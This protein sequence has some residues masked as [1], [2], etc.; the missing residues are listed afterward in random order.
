V[1]LEQF[2]WSTNQ[3]ISVVMTLGDTETGIATAAATVAAIY[4]VLAYHRPKG[5]PVA[6]AATR[7]VRGQVAPEP[8]RPRSAIP[9]IAALV[10]W[11]AVA[12]NFV[13]TNWF[14][15]EL[16]GAETALSEDNASIS[17]RFWQRVMPSSDAHQYFVNVYTLNRGKST[18]IGM[19]HTGFAAVGAALDRSIADAFYLSLRAQLK[20]ATA[21]ASANEIRPGQD[22]V[23]F[24]LVGPPETETMTKQIND[25]SSVIYAFV[26]MRY[27]DNATPKGKYIYTEGCAYF[28]KETTHLCEIGHNRTY[29]SD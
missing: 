7:G 18:A 12:C 4:A 8:V 22:D 13:Y 24:T 19:M 11:A 20:I 9:I 26:I 15:S 14:V 23:W 28:A 27:R 21:T 6:R 10:A 2:Q 5:T 25:G 29:I 1:P 16:P 17:V 3:I